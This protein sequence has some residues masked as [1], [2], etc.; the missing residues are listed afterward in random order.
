MSASREKQLRQELAASGVPDTKAELAKEQ[1]KKEKRSNTLYITVA[2]VFLLALVASVVWRSNVIGKNATAVTIDGEKYSAAEV[3]FYYW[4][5]YNNFLNNYSYLVSYMGLNTAASPES[6][7]MNETAVDM[8]GVE[9]GS[10]WYDYFTDQ[11]HQQMAVIQVA[12]DKAEAEG[13]TYTDAVQTQYDGTIESLNTTAAANGA[14]L[15]TYLQNAYGPLMSEKVFTEQLMRVSK[16][17]DYINSYYTGLEFS[18]AEIEAAYA[19]DTNSYDRISYQSVSVPGAAA[20]TKDADGNTVEPTEEESAAA[21]AKA[22]ATAEK[23]LADYKAGGDLKALAEAA[24]GANYSS[25]DESSYFSSDLGLWLF[26]EARKAGDCTVIESGTTYYVAAFGERFR[27]EEPT[28]D[29]R[30]ILIATAAGELTSEDEG[31]EAEQAQLKA[32]AKAK[33]DALLAEW[34]AG[35]ATEESFAA[36]ATANTEDPGS[37]ATGGLYEYVYEGQMV[38]EF[39][40]WCFDPARKSGDTGVVETSYGAHVMYYVGENMPLWQVEVDSALRADAY[41]EWLTTLPADC[42]ITA[43]DFGMGFVG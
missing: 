5:G 30:H 4:N 18:E 34:K 28:Q 38:A 29:V 43:D 12:L 17:S 21:L 26:D 10:T 37:A 6:Q 32:E 8:L 31:Y 14:T 19:A 23:L 27:M 22:K 9:E 2:V 33:A 1:A 39:N 42:T 24:E 20:S 41:N 3:N 13:Y 16:Y 15:K 25:N 40:D 11:A 36:L 7:V 35:E